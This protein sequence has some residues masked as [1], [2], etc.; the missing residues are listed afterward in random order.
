MCISIGPIPVFYDSTGIGQVCYTSTNSVVGALLSIK[1]SR[2]AKIPK[3]KLILT[4]HSIVFPC[5]GIG[6][7]TCEYI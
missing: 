5:I 1:Q 2:Q 4:T 7:C 3:T 6:T